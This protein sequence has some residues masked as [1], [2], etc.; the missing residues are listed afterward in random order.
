MTNSSCRTSTYEDR[1]TARKTS[2]R[3]HL[4]AN[5]ATRLV[6]CDNCDGWHLESSDPRI[7]EQNRKI[8]TKVAQ[9]LRAREIAEDLG[10]TE[11]QVNYCVNEEMMAVFGALSRPNLIAIAIW[12]RVVDL[13]SI[14]PDFTKGPDLE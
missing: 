8:L 7:D 3:I 12:L 11:R 5:L 14:M 1:P 2:R 9:G 10:L 6:H 13:E 4:R